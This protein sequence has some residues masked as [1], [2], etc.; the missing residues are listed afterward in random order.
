MGSSQDVKLAILDN[1]QDAKKALAA[2][3][4]ARLATDVSIAYQL[5]CFGAKATDGQKE[6]IPAVREPASTKR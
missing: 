1:G 5:Y 4:T 2:E 6:F 3:G